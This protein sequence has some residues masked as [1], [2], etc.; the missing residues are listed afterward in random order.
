MLSLLEKAIHALDGNYDVCAWSKV[1]E[2]CQSDESLSLPTSPLLEFELKPKGHCN[3]CHAGTWRSSRHKVGWA[4]QGYK[5]P[6]V[7]STEKLSEPDEEGGSR[8]TKKPRGEVLSGE[9]H[10]A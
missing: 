9:P 7:R 5:H 8:G 10:A 6:Q 3:W 4:L 1:I 2:L